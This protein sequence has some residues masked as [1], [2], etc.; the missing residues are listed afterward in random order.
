MPEEVETEAPVSQ[1]KK[2]NLK[3]K[4]IVIFSLVV[5]IFVAIF[6]L[7]NA[8]TQAPLKA[9]NEF[10]ADI[11]AKNSSAAY[12]H[13]SV[14]AKA[15]VNEDDFVQV[16]D[17][18]GPILSGEPKVISKEISGE[19]GEAA[20]ARV[21]YEIKGSDNITYT[22]TVNLTKDNGEWKILNFD[23]AKK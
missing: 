13:F 6:V 4:L 11:Q 16:V 22:F 10:V 23:S 19:T 15:V 20:T 9:S 12:S 2:W 21:V 17:Q 7:A 14:D 5:G 18:I 3:K 8:A 1:K